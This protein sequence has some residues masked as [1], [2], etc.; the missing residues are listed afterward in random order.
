M[1]GMSV[2]NVPFWNDT[3]LS[4]PRLGT[5]F[6]KTY[7]KKISFWK[8][9]LNTKKE[10]LPDNTTG[11]S[12]TVAAIPLQTLHHLH[13]F[14]F[15]IFCDNPLVFPI[16]VSPPLRLEPDKV[17]YV[18]QDGVEGGDEDERYRRGHHYAHRKA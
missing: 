9:F 4:N 11:N 17:H 13:R 2:K 14:F 5:P 10:R 3:M 16:P 15:V 8:T 1:L 18:F 7:Y 6:S 12:P